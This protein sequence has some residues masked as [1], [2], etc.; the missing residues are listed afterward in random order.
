MVSAAVTVAAR[1][2]TADSLT[3][4]V[5]CAV[6][7]TPAAARE[8]IDGM[9]DVLTVECSHLTVAGEDRAAAI[10]IGLFAD[11]LDAIDALEG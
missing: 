4:T 11:C 10:V 3:R 8:L 2:L 7:G 9:C 5:P 6:L 1:S